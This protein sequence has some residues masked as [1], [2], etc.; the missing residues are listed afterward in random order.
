MDRDRLVTLFRH[1]G[2]IEAE[3]NFSPLY[4]VFGHAV[5]DDDDLLGLASEAL[6][7]QPPPNILFGAV[8]GLLALRPDEPLAEYYATLGGTRP[9]DIH[10][11]KLLR[12][13]CLR[14]REELLPVIRTRLVQTNEVRRSAILLPAFAS[15]AAE[16]SRPLA[17][18]EI[19]PSAGL[20]LLFDRYQ[21]R[22]GN[23]R[24]GDRSSPVV[25]D[26]EPR[27]PFPS[28][29]IPGVVAGV[30]IDIN[31]LDVTGETDVAWLRALLW[32]EH[33]DRLALMNAAIDVARKEPPRLF[34]GDIF[35]LLP[36][37]V[38]H[39]PS[40]ASV[41]IFATF[42]LNQFTPEMLTRLRG[43]LLALSHEREL[44]LVVMGFSEFIE[45]GTPR[46]G[47]MKVWVLRLG[48]G[49]GEYRLSSLANPHGRWIELQS[50]SPWKA[51]LLKEATR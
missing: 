19:G 29:D 21:Y 36:G 12:E 32:P 1:W 42:V 8:H 2:D 3:A 20:N 16:T 44:H 28:L 37:E 7:G 5:A 10:A 15:I 23:L 40:G 38:Q 30:G 18:V 49:A 33:T 43:L 26:S 4:A 46:A 31:P 13:F 45:P 39:A 11:A 27:G 24:V 41:C 22:Y 6:P 17:L 14:R 50:D 34:R 35:E 25:L 51:W 48:D 9:A 47:D